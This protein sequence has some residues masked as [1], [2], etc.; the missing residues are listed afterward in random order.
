MIR[1]CGFNP[2]AVGFVVSQ[3]GGI[4]A[5]CKVADEVLVW[6]KVRIHSLRT[7]MFS[8]RQQRKGSL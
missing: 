3:D 6:D 1:Y 7:P 2:A 8:K 5:V 4:K